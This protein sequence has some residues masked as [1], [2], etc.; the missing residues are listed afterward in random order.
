MIVRAIFLVLLTLPVA[1]LWPGLIRT[2]V[3]LKLPKYSSFPVL[4]TLYLCILAGIAWLRPTNVFATPILGTMVVL[5]I[6]IWALWA[7]RLNLNRDVW[8]KELPERDE[9]G[10]V[11]PSIKA[12]TTHGEP[13]DSE[14]DR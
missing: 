2:A 5:D 1:I 6:L 7:V 8:E 14:I 4:S 10:I 13:S 12:A 11:K 3:T 9:M